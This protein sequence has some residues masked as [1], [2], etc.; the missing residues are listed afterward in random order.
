MDSLEDKEV[1][2]KVCE[3]QSGSSLNLLN[4]NSSQFEYNVPAF[5]DMPAKPKIVFK[6]QLDLNI[7]ENRSYLFKQGP[8]VTKPSS[9]KGDY[10]SPMITFENV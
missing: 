4:E 6:K 8:V 9:P 5:F 7:I 2:L 1:T 3:E 10:S